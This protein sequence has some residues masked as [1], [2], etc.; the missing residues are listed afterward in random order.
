MKI[1]S[2]T[3]KEFDDVVQ[4]IYDVSCHKENTTTGCPRSFVALQN[5]IR[6]IINHPHDQVLVCYDGKQIRG[7][8]VVMIDV[9]HKYMLGIGGP[10]IKTD[11][12]KIAMKF[13]HLLRNAYASFK[14]EFTYPEENL[15][16][17]YFMNK[18][19]ATQY[20]PQIE[21][22]LNNDDKLESVK[23]RNIH[24][25][26]EDEVNE[27]IKLYKTETF[28]W[29]PES[30]L[31]NIDKLNIYV[32]ALDKEV[33]GYSIVS[34][35]NH[36]APEILYFGFKNEYM[37]SIYPKRL[38]ENVIIECLGEGKLLKMN[39]SCNDKKTQSIL[40]ELNFVKKDIT[41]SY[42]AEF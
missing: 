38:L 14:M 36:K 24:L 5:H 29:T 21:Y 33:V 30:V 35:T 23:H 10:F 25:L 7:V 16:A 6:K 26:K 20:V 11:Y 12:K 32:V 22:V 42:Y 19:K 15:K 18:I 31:Q 17:Q 4:Y 40:K 28:F 27:F 3:L 8:L 34:K 13:Y 41:I 9:E 1:I 37:E 39:I 2:A